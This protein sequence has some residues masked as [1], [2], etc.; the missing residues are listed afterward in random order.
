[1]VLNLK[2]IINLFFLGLLVILSGCSRSPDYYDETTTI[3][4]ENGIYSARTKFQD[5]KES[6]G[7]S[8]KFDPTEVFTISA[9]GNTANAINNSIIELHKYEA[10]TCRHWA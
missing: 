5:I 1:M 7:K 10:G 9:L 2:N 8:S 4:D 6:N 3:E